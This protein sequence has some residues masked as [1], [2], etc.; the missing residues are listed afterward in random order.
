M[1]PYI[2]EIQVNDCYTYQDFRIE[3]D[4]SSQEGKVF[5]HIVLTGKN[6]SGKTTILD[7]V[8]YLFQ[9]T[10][11]HKT[12]SQLERT[13]RSRLNG[14]NKTVVQN[15]A[16]ELNE[17]LRIDINSTE[18]FDIDQIFSYWNENRQDFVYAYFKA[19]RKTEVKQV[20]T[21]TKE[22]D[23]LNKLNHNNQNTENFTNQF[24]QYLVNKKV[25][26]V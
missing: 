8:D 7:S 25:Y 22:T 13:L 26:E 24:K 9:K 10:Q 12:Y 16:K 17:L 5:K 3:A 15:S 18:S 4:A 1:F 14:A 20:N 23:F 2:K 19:G 21:V 6:G 11:G